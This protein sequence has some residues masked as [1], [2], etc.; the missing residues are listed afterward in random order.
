MI[1]EGK[2]HNM[3]S[4]NFIVP[5]SLGLET[6]V[7]AVSVLAV[8]STQAVSR[9]VTSVHKMKSLIKCTFAVGPFTFSQSVV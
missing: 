8:T 4:T 3:Q 7:K 2:Q 6:N 9:L 1:T 5:K